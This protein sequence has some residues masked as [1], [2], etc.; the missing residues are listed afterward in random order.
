MSLF[1]FCL[2]LTFVDYVPVKGEIIWYL[3]LIAWL[4]CFHLE[5]EYHLDQIFFVF[6]ESLE[7]FFACFP[8]TTTVPS[9][10]GREHRVWE[11]R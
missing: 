4:L 5:T 2:L 1:I 8:I 10:D 6:E 7:G 3:S 9:G 11:E